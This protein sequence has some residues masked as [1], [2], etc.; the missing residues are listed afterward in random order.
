MLLFLPGLICDARIFAAQTAAFPQSR[1]VDG[2]GTADSLQGM[3]RIVLDSAPDRFDLFGHSMGGRVALEVWRLAPE[4]VRRLAL[5]STGVHSVTPG[6]PEK[7]AE[8]QQL[9]YRSGFP[10]LVDRWL[11]P[12][13]APANRAEEGMYRQMRR[14]CLDAGQARFDAHVRALLG[15][16]VQDDL[17]GGIACP[18]LVMTGEWDGWAPPA[19]HA[20]IAGR[21]ADAMLVTVSGAGHMLPMEAPAATNAAIA[22]WL[23]MAAAD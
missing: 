19:Q 14:M 1:A 20:A 13:V 22:D 15:R 21:I 3:A 2:Y 23:K 16:P 11:P 10:A 7:R 18:T 9:G 8:L 17:P 6:E 5:C 4:R 12:M